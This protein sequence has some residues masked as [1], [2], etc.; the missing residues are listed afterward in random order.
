MTNNSKFWT[1]YPLSYRA[2]IKPTVVNSLQ[3]IRTMKTYTAQ[4]P[5]SNFSQAFDIYEF[6]DCFSAVGHFPADLDE[7]SQGARVKFIPHAAIL[8]QQRCAYSTE[9]DIMKASQFHKCVVLWLSRG[10]HESTWWCCMNF[11]LKPVNRKLLSVN[12]QTTGLCR[13]L[14]HKDK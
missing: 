5:A 2:G 11:K 12:H 8:S 6:R 4:A 10:A 7:E 9:R 1:V 3:C 13:D 14:S